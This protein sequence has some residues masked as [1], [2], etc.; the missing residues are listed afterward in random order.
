MA[1]SPTNETYYVVMFDE[2]YG[3]GNTL[4]QAA[5]AYYNDSDEYPPEEA[6]WIKGKKISVLLQE[7]VL[8]SFVEE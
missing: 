8:T 2:K 1:K 6:L 7:V 4:Q 5:D 3:C